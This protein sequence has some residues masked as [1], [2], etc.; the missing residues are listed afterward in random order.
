MK[1]K[2]L[3]AYSRLVKDYEHNVDTESPYNA[4][5]E[6][7][8]MMKL[9]PDDMSGLAVLDAGCAAPAGT[10]SNWYNAVQQR[11]RSI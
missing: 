2:V 8:A 1:E 9:L 5:Y 4:H 6:R 10:R 7:P 3:E 11:R